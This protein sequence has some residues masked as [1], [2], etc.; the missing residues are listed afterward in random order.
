MKRTNC[1]YC[2]KPLINQTKWCS[3]SCQLDGSK[4]AKMVDSA[5]GHKR[6]HTQEEEATFKKIKDYLIK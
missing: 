5:R 6:I 3:I 1:I 4:I 2:S